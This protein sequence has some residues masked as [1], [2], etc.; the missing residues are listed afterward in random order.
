MIEN[1]FSTEGDILIK[2]TLKIN[3]V[4]PTIGSVPFTL[5]Y[6]NPLDEKKY[7]EASYDGTDYINITPEND[8]YII[9]IDNVELLPGRMFCWEKIMVD[10]DYHKDG[11]K[12]ESSRYDIGEILKVFTSDININEQVNFSQGVWFNYP[13]KYKLSLPTVG[14][15]NVVYFIPNS[16]TSDLYMYIENSWCHLGNTNIDL[17]NYSLIDTSFLEEYN[18]SNLGANV[19]F[20]AYDEDNEK[21]KKINIIEIFRFPTARPLKGVQD[22]SNNEFTSDYKYIK[23]SERL[24]INGNIYYEK[25]GFSC[26]EEKIIL[27][28]KIIPHEEDIMLLDAIYTE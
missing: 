11:K 25:N 14:E 9:A 10:S 12:T 7:Y 2:Y 24:N 19:Y 3:G 22:G 21:E 27:D 4:T 15:Y 26:N 5:R 23:G 13:S 18:I 28:E 20:K 17:S 8:Y 6:Y 16:T 1:R